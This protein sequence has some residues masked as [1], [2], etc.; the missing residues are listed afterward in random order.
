M[1]TTLRNTIKT[2]DSRLFAGTLRKLNR[3]R[4]KYKAYR[5]EKA[6]LS[7]MHAKFKYNNNACFTSKKQNYLGELFDKY[8]SDKG[9]YLHAYNHENNQDDFITYP[10]GHGYNDIYE[11][12]FFQHKNN[13]RLVL[14][15]GIGSKNLET[16]ENMSWSEFNIPGGS[17]RAWRDYFPHAQIIGI[18]IDPDIIFTEDRIKTYVCDQT[19]AESIKKFI[20]Q[21]HLQPN[22]VDIIIDDGLHEFN[23]NITLFENTKHLL[24]NNGIYVIEDVWVVNK[25][26]QQFI[27]YFSR[28]SGYNVRIIKVCVAYL[29]VITKKDME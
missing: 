8:G 27:D 23:A 18:D 12:L 17:L 25:E 13:T 2:I 21:A 15:C 11:L 6:Y 4:C 7:K 29:I 28:L 20:Y 19:K 3:H 24:K 22:T 10:F 1:N 16:P 5:E 14:E 26:Q 9:Y